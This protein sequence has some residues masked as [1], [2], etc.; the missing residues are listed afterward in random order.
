MPRSRAVEAGHVNV[1]YYGYQLSRDRLFQTGRAGS[2]WGAVADRGGDGFVVAQT[3]AKLNASCMLNPE[4]AVLG[5][6]WIHTQWGPLA[7][8][9]GNA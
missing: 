3:D 2:S 7:A 9:L 4:D 1:S 6:S 5:E 8:F